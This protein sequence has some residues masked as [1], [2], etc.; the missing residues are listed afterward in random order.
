[1]VV[2]S[3]DRF[4]SYTI[5]VHLN[6]EDVSAKHVTH[7]MSDTVHEHICACLSKQTPC[8]GVKA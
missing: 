2:R 4:T 3:T 1:M 6:T 8:I 7:S 5:H